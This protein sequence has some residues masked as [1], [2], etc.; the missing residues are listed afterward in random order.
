MKLAHVFGDKNAL[1]PDYYLKLFHE[2]VKT[3]ECL[4]IGKVDGRYLE[5]IT[6]EFTYSLSTKFLLFCTRVM[7]YASYITFPYF[8]PFRS[9]L[10]HPWL[11][12]L[13]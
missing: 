7:K 5:E 1:A 6:A 3:A 2:L 8:L 13:I 12:I 9:V 11:F 4:Q 10:C